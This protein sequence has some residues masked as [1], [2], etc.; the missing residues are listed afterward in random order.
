MSF[1]WRLGLTAGLLA[2][3]VGFVVLFGAFSQWEKASRKEEVGKLRGAAQK[4][5]MQL[6][7]LLRLPAEPRNRQVEQLGALMG[8]RVTLVAADGTVVADSRVPYQHLPLLENH[9]QRPEVHGALHAGEA[10]AHRRSSTTGALTWYLAWRAEDQGQVWVVRFAKEGKP[11]RFPWLWLVVLAFGSA[12]VGWTAQ[13]LFASWQHQ[14]YQHLASWCELPASAETPAVAY[15]AD[16]RFRSLREETSREL[17]ACRQALSRVAEGVV[18]LDREQVVRFANPAA[19]EL[20]G[21]LPEGGP[22]WEH[23]PNPQLLALVGEGLSGAE[24]RHAEITHNGRTLALTLAS[25]QHPVL[26]LAIL[27]RDI[28][29]QARFE[30]ARRAFVADLAHELRTP[31]TVLGGVLEELKEQ[32]VAPQLSEMLGRQVQRLSRFAA[33]LEEL[34]RIETGRLQLVPSPVDLLALAQEVAADFAARAQSREVSLRVE[35][36]PVTVVTDRTR[37]A[38]VISNLVENAI[39]YNRPQGSVTVRVTPRPEGAQVV[40]EDSG[41]GIPESEIPLVFQRF[42]RVRRGEAEGTGSGLGLAIVKHLV[43][44]LGGRVHLASKLGEGTRVTV[45][46]PWEPPSEPP[47]PSGA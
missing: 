15:E 20:L 25:L 46:L 17:E 24:S 9:R 7:E 8:V 19:F 10:I 47:A 35:G 13:R 12:G 41:L 6:P 5:A 18:L 39:L 33:D 36:Q 22:L 3:G 4:L 30:A 21:K 37:L 14:V 16:R 42:Y 27:V 43:A 38:Q 29:P 34:V 45:E 44:R 1:R 28:S 11:S 23:C 26:A 32:E 31:I 2:L 40:V